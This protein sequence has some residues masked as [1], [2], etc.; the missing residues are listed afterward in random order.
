MTN[1]ANRDV[2]MQMRRERSTLF[3]LA[4][5]AIIVLLV[6]LAFSL[7]YTP[8]N[9]F[10]QD[11][12]L[13]VARNVVNGQGYSLPDARGTTAK[14]GPA[15]VY[16]FAAVV[17]LFGDGIWP[18]IIAQWL[19]DVGTA[20][21][22]FF[23]ALEIF[24]D[25]RVA[26]I[27]SLLFA[28]YGPGISLTLIALSEPVFTLLLA[29]FTLSLL[30]GLRQPLI[31]RFALSGVLLGIAT[32]ARAVMQF[33]PIFVLPVMFW[34]LDR[35]WRLVLPR[36]AV[37]CIAFAAVLLPWTVRN[38]LLF[39]AFIP[40]SSHTSGA[41]Y[42]SYFALGEPDYL[43]YRSVQEKNMALIQALES[44]FGPVPGGSD[45]LEDYVVSKGLSEDEVNQLAQQEGMKAIRAHPGR[46]VIQSLWSFIRLWF[47]LDYG[48]NPSLKSYLTAVTNGTLLGLA[49]VALICFRSGG[50]LRLAVPLIVLVGFNT[51]VYTV[52]LGIARYTVPVMPYCMVLAAQTIVHLL[53]QAST[54]GIFNRASWSSARRFCGLSGRGRI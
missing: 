6:R 41:I 11:H 28:F 32:L 51:A 30:R 14:R 10:D 47:S 19:A 36:F 20:I 34:S 52:A 45:K 48:L 1:F 8:D 23:I 35:Q 46:A 38:Y 22:V 31:W 25:R 24:K 27:S 9:R 12:W 29:G 54:S 33:Y 21:L 16:F 17:W 42:K 4:L 15:V 39:D 53:P 37:L 44:R 3:N 18:I 43:R 5:I 50:W 2:Q 40:A 26:F 13:A 7:V 49:V